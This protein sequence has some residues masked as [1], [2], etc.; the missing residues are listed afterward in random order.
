MLY[1]FD[2]GGVVT[3]TANEIGKIAKI[4]DCSEDDFKNWCRGKNQDEDLFVLASNG[5]IGSKE[6][7]KIFSQRSG[8]DVKIDWWHWLFHPKLIDGTVDIIQVL[9]KQ[10]H[11]VVCGTNTTEA[12]YQ[13][14]LERGDYALFEKTYASNFMGISKPDPEFWKL[15]LMAENASPSETVFIDDKIENVNAAKS[16]GIRGIHFENPEQLKK[17]LDILG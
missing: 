1:I 4:L 13:I 9:K 5:V 2:M 6:F 10:G 17:E 16:L 8:I 7:W 3:N 12:Y 14:H 11:R 15:I